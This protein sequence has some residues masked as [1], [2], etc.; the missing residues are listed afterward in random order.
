V[1][2]LKGILVN[3]LFVGVVFAFMLVPKLNEET[4]NGWVGVAL[5]DAAIILVITASGGALG[6]VIKEIK[7]G[8][9]LGQSLQSLNIGIFVPFIIA[10]ALKTAQ[11]SSTVAMV[12]T[13]ALLFPILPALGFTTEIAKVLVVMAI[14]AG[15]MTVSHVND[16]YFRVVSQFGGMDVKTAY[17]TQTVATLLQGIVTIL[18]TFILTLFL[19]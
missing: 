12:T 15:A 2:C 1:L 16:S 3:A 14:G 4:L 19:I 18:T 13:S 6:N 8:D 17:K 10:A 7:I 11:G 5:K 9:Y